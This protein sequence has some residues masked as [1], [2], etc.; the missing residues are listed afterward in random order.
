MLYERTRLFV[1]IGSRNSGTM[2]MPRRLI[3]LFDQK[4]KK[5]EILITKQTIRDVL[6]FG[7]APDDPVEYPKQKIM[8][9]PERMSY[10]GTYPPTTKKLLHP[11]L[12]FLA[13]VYLVYIS[14]NMSGIDSLT[15]KQTLGVVALVEN[16]SFNY[17]KCIFED[18]LANVKSIN[19]KCWLK[20]PKLLQMIL[21]A[22]YSS[23]QQTVS[24]YDTKMMNHTVFGLLKQV[25][26]DVQVMYKN[27]RPLE[28]FGAFPEIVEPAPAPVNASVA[29]EH[30]V[31]IV[32][33]PPRVKEPI[34]SIDLTE[35]ESEEENIENVSEENLMADTEVDEH[36]GEGETEIETESLVAERINEDQVLSVNPPHTTIFEQVFAESDVMQED[37]TTDLLP[38]KRS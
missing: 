5:K 7:D 2:L 34:E 3:V 27:R 21:E 16:W 10:D 18:M 1:K 13:H 35:V 33:A 24:I 37:P 30:D 32:D 26:K 8:S 9:V 19:K 11:Y 25:R 14:G 20:F 38:R 29:E 23:L 31:E 4:F 36:D 17:S 28:R 22:K 6:L 12:R 15:I